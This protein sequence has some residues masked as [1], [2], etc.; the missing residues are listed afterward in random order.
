MGKL[1]KRKAFKKEVLRSI[2][3][4]LSRFGAILVIVALGAG[5]YAGLRS[6]A[7][8][9]RLTVDQYY[10]STHFMD[11]HL[12]STLGFTDEDVEKIKETPGVAGVMD[13]YTADVFFE[14]DG[15]EKVARIH[16]LPTDQRADNTDYLNRPVLVEGRLPE[17]SGE[18]VMDKGKGD[19]GGIQVG[20]TISL[21][22]A[23]G[24]LADT[25]RCQEY[26]VVGLVNSSY[27]ISFSLGSTTI[28]NGTLS[29]YIYVPESDFLTEFKTDLHVSVAGAQELSTFDD[30]YWSTVAPVK[31]ALEELG[32]D[33]AS[34]RYDDIFSE[35][36]QQLDDAQAAYDENK[37]KAQAELDSAK[38]Q[39]DDAGRQIAENEQKLAE[40]R[41]QLQ[42][43]RSSLADAEKKLKQSEEE[44]NAGVEELEAQ[45]KKLQD[46]TAQLD[47]KA[48]ELE[49]QA[50]ALAQQREQLEAALPAVEQ[51]RENL[52]LLTETVRACQEELDKLPEDD[53][54][55]PTLESQ[56]QAAQEN[57][58]A[59]QDTVA[60][61]E[62]GMAR[63]AAG[64]QQLAAARLQLEEARKK[65]EQQ[66][67]AVQAQIDAAQQQLDGARAQL[68]SGLAALEQNR[69]RIESGERELK[70][71]AAKLET[72]KTELA[73][74]RTEYEESKA[75]A[76]QELADAA[77]KIADGREDLEKL[78]EPEWYVLDRKTNVGFASIDADTDR[79]ESLS[80]IF[81]LLFFLVAALVALTTM[82]RM[83]EEDR[84]IIGTYKALG[85]SK[86]K[87]I[88]KY[89]FYAA[90]ASIVGSVAGV[91]LG[92]WGL[93]NICWNSY[94][95]L[96][97][98]PSLV[99]N[100]DF[101]YAL[102]GTLAAVACTLAA[103]LWACWSTL[104]ESPAALMLPRAPKAGKRILLE[105]AG[106]IW[107]RL[108]FTHKVTCRNLFRY[109]KRLIMTIVGI[110]GC[111]ALL[112]T[113]FGIKDS[114]SDIMSKQYDG[115][116]RYDT[117][118][119]TDKKQ[120]TADLTDLLDDP[121][122]FSG[123][124]RAYQRSAE[125]KNG[126][127]TIT[128]YL[129][130]PEDTGALKSFINLRT[131]GSGAD[132]PFDEGSAVL[133][134]KTAR[135]LGVDVGG[136]V[137]L[138]NDDGEDVSFTVTGITEN[139][140]YHY[141]YIAPE[142]YAE[143]M[144]KEPEYN[145]IQAICSIPA[146]QADARQSLLDSLLE[147]RGVST[148]A[149]TTDARSSFD[150]MIASLN[151]V[152]LVII[153]C[154]GALAFVV[155]YNLTNINITERQREIATIK[156]LGFFDRE[157]SAYIYRETA[158]LTLMGCALGLVL[159]IFMHLFVIQT[160]EVEL[161][162]FGRDIHALSFVWSAALTLAFS[163]VVNLV[164]Y[165]KLKKI[166]M[167]ESLKSVD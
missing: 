148:A 27:Y 151:Y 164:M 89:V 67:A 163:L 125:L 121:E 104:A 64:E 3:H 68:D 135:L 91:A 141:L 156:V 58:K 2:T 93:P 140:I 13:G 149:F 82:T 167:V 23:S 120:L 28:G 158:L 31:T 47:E 5:F 48:A 111:T 114:V 137:T 113:G 150:D 79:M 29:R 142:V 118:V 92:S 35:A 46:P 134:E 110:A 128:A 94:R 22:T 20:D 95:I 145:E 59:C 7:P 122:N 109:K 54:L 38:R 157:V 30:A 44:Y 131:R 33:R 11:L 40:S 17:K 61:Y 99:P 152:I 165:H 108:K 56:L 60:A 80:T 162:M 50:Q 42:S 36:E 8:D 15:K 10:D 73:S 112:L 70:I 160:V 86:G 153:L 127:N 53:P 146:D 55:R 45:K 57:L 49:K 74:G 51:C 21:Y 102:I 72:A 124:Q 34:I 4:S 14:V 43:G 119:E 37:Q 25:L 85:Y 166:D 139:Y 52:P 96:Y 62:E 66:L 77:Q 116:Y 65:A 115:I 18:C 123:W 87:I 130:V 19:L 154:A 16:S 9:M 78:S 117:V 138:E 39:L 97:I 88:F 105:R 133:S 147:K 143:K 81:P 129:F 159:G 84:V 83:V 6:T 12:I 75:K 76:E 161:V 132:V 98:A 144:G 103:T 106:F 90:S 126:G 107:K 24:D 101:K 100:F 155:L 41:R 26:T 71:G 32:R 136:A 1:M 63:V 69:S